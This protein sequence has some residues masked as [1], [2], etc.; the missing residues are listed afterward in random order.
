[1][2][3]NFWQDEK[4]VRGIHRYCSFEDYK[5]NDNVDEISWTNVLNLDELGKLENES[6]VYKGVIELSPRADALSQDKKT[7]ERVIYELSRG[8]ADAEVLREFCLKTKTFVD[9]NSSDKGFYVPEGKSSINFKSRDIAILS[10]AIEEDDVTSSG[11]PLKVREWVR[12]T[13][14]ESSKVIFEG[15]KT[16]VSVFAYINDQRLRGEGGIT[17]WRGRSTTFWTKKLWVRQIPP[18]DLQCE[19]RNEDSNPFTELKV[20]DDAHVSMFGDNLLISLRSDWE[21]NGRT[22][23]KGGMYSTNLASFLENH[24]TATFEDIFV[25]TDETALENYTYTKNFL[26]LKIMD[27]VKSVHQFW[28]RKASRWTKIAQTDLGDIAETHYSPYDSEN[29]DKVWIYKSG[30]T[31]PTTLYFSDANDPV[32][33]H[34]I[35]NTPI[36]TTKALF[37]A[38]SVEV[39]QGFAE[40]KDGTKVPYFIVKKKDADIPNAPTLLYGYGGFEISLTPS[41]RG[42]LGSCWLE[43]GGVYVEANIRGGGEYGPRWHQAALKENR[44]L[45]FDDFIAVGEHLIKTGICTTKTLGCKGGSNGGLLMGMMLVQRPDLFNAIHCQVPLLD[46]KAYNKLLAGA[47][48]MAEYGN[49]DTDDW[50]NFLHRYS[51]Y[52]LIESGKKYC[53]ILFTTSTRDDRVHPAHARKMV[54]KLSEEAE[55]EVYYYEN[56]EGGHGGAADNKQRSFMETLN[57]KFLFAKLSNS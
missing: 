44:Q 24:E 50:K 3:W 4:N 32:I 49:P 47:S 2:L 21:V 28:Q 38:S 34:T 13:P 25:P 15:E 16:D 30:Y 29:D 33:K 55:G 6:W 51:P 11:Y 52:H 43:K 18:E 27:N 31:Q 48:W 57:Y 56:M 46:M 53:P 40:S 26:I 20:Q 7:V 22:M 1:M 54:K 42:V 8:G 23:K 35:E 12:G 14:M 17:E 45:A 5:N 36:K 19:C 10:L 41:Y 37:D 9:P 39:K